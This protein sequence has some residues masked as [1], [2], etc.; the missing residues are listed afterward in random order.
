M[1]T[2]MWFIVT[3]ALLALII[4]LVELIHSGKLDQFFS[5]S[6]KIGRIY[7]GTWRD[8]EH[9]QYLHVANV[10]SIVVEICNM[11]EDD[12]MWEWM[13]S[14]FKF[15]LKLLEETREKVQYCHQLNESLADEIDSLIDATKERVTEIRDELNRLESKPDVN[16]GSSMSALNTDFDGDV[17]NIHRNEDTTI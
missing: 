14:E 13:D 3:M 16:Q 15:Y 8:L 2:F 5:P 12:D 7:D 11:Y 6:G 17:L 10:V 1:E 4:Y 9:L